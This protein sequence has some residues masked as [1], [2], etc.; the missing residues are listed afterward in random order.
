MAANA[1]V[2]RHI[3]DLCRGCRDRYGASSD[4]AGW[5][6]HIT[7][8][9]AEFAVAKTLGHYWPGADPALYE[10]GDVALLQVR[11]TTRRD[12]C[13]IVHPADPDQAAYVLVVGVPPGLLI[14]GW[15]PGTEAKAE[16]YWRDGE[17]PAFFVPQGALRPLGELVAVG[18]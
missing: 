4:E 17:R 12:G 10:R 7:G 13:L 2:D 9:L 8:V 15:L 1:G 5:Q 18:V 6:M 16:R 14:P 3:M 11:S